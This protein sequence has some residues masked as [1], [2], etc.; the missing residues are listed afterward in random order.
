MIL[1]TRTS[2]LI[3]NETKRIGR[4]NLMLILSVYPIILGLV[5]KFL[6]P[7]LRESLVHRFD[8][9]PYYSGIFIFF[10]LANPYIYGALAA[11]S[12]LDEREE[13]ILNAIRVTPVKLQ[14]YLLSK[15]FFIISVSIISGMLI[16]SFIGLVEISIWESFIIN[17]LMSFLAPF[18]MMLINT[19]AKNRVE[20]FALVKGTGFMILL[21]IVAIYIPHPINLI[22]GVI[23][24]YWP[25]MAINSLTN[26]EFSFLPYW[27][28][29]LCGFIYIALAIRILY[30]RFSE[31]LHS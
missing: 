13:N 7:F 27:I 5:G 31:K 12:L 2:K 16:T 10:I 11:F 1:V 21:P 24:G 19:F 14:T 29:V 20:G 9:L 18:N 28:Y 22:F 3:V 23:P 4:D 30:N 8:I 26:L 15:V 17:T 6:V 25:A